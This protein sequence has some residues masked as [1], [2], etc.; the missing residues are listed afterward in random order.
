M[1]MGDQ[2][3]TRRSIRELVTFVD[4]ELTDDKIEDRKRQVLRQIEAVEVV[5]GPRKVQGEARDSAV[6]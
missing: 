3:E 1:T 2:L 6:R 5:D 4:E